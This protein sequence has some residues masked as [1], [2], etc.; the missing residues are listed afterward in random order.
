MTHAGSW[1]H[2]T[3]RRQ[4]SFR[5]R[6]L[7]RRNSSW[8]PSIRRH[9]NHWHHPLLADCHDAREMPRLISGILPEQFERDAPA[10]LSRSE[11]EATKSSLFRPVGR[12]TS[13]YRLAT[14]GQSCGICHHCEVDRAQPGD[15]RDGTPFTRNESRSPNMVRANDVWIVAKTTCPITKVAS[16]TNIAMTILPTRPA[17]RRKV[18]AARKPACGWC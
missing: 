14:P 1:R 7:D 2:A 16:Q 17:P 10:P 8:A 12:F 3:S 11:P 18:G 13:R 5:L 9:M 6:E 15:V 4:R